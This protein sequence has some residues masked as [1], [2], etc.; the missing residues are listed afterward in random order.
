MENL[1]RAVLLH[2]LGLHTEALGPPEEWQ[3]IPAGPHQ[4]RHSDFWF[5]VAALI[6]SE[7]GDYDDLPEWMTETG[8][9]QLEANG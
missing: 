1:D 9:E 8:S 7:P 3:P 2:R 5:M 4:R 6:K